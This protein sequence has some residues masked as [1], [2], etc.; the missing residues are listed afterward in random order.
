[1]IKPSD[2]VKSI[3]QNLF[4]VIVFTVSFSIF[5]GTLGAL[6][7]VFNKGSFTAR[8][9]SALTGDIAWPVFNGGGAEL[10][11]NYNESTLDSTNVSGLTKLWQA[12]TPAAVDTALV[13]WPNVSTPSGVK[14]MVFA[15]TIKGNLLAFDAATGTKVW[16]A[17]PPSSNFNGQGTKSTPAIDPSGTAIYAYA[18]DG[19][20]HK[21]NLGTGAELK[22]NGFPI[23]A[24]ILPNDIEK[25]SSSLNIG[26][27]YLYMTFSGN[28]G[29]YGHYTGHVVAVKLATGTKTVWNAE[30]SD[31]RQLLGE[32]GTNYCS[33]TMAGIWERAGAVID[34]VTGNIFVTTG[35]GN[36]NADSGGNNW[37]DSVI[38]LKPDLSQV[39]DS[40]TPPNYQ[41][42]DDDDLD[43]GSTGPVVLPTQNNSSKPYLLAQGG[44]DHKLRLL[45]RTNLSGQGGPRHV[46]NELDSAP[47]GAEM[48]GQP[49]VWVDGSG[50]TWIFCTDIN[51]GFYAFK[52]VSSSG[53]PKLQ[54]VYSTYNLNLTASPFV[55]NGVVYVDGKSIVALEP[56]TGKVLFDSQSVGITLNDHWESPIVVNGTLFTADNGGNVYALSNPN[57]IHK[58]NN[59]DLNGDGKVNI[60]DLALLLINFGKTGS[61][62]KGDINNDGKVNIQDLALLLVKFGK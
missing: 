58:N 15:I 21:Y 42:L 39:V 48:H 19:Y 49:A 13:E 28:D 16:E 20:I 5:V 6:A 26:N 51:G 47:I 53:A 7:Y 59:A 60:Q 2:I 14:D 35:N 33:N 23:Q 36:Y 27:G 61:S 37:G 17:D 10:G 46:S 43:L 38:E 4:A 57:A 3:R 40:Y 22:T 12:S 54:Q 32:S 24:T 44:K 41:S 45:D 29:D 55:A 25:G 50:V 8:H 62:L 52:V 30:C 34:P 1:M 31:I 11:T 18:L 56:T 9:G